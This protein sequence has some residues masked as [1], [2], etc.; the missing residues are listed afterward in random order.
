[1]TDK[2][3]Q[4]PPKPDQPT[5][6]EKPGELDLGE[7][8]LGRSALGQKSSTSPA[9]A[10]ILGLLIGV[11]AAAGAILGLGVGRP[12]PP[13]IA[14]ATASATPEPSA[15][16]SARAP[17]LGPLERAAQGDADA[18][19]ALEAR[20][21]DKR[22]AAE[23]IAL[24]RGRAAT[25][26][27]GIDEIKHKTEL[28]PDY[29]REKDTVS[30]IREYARD[31][32]MAIDVLEMLASLEGAVGPDLIFRIDRDRLV[33]D[34]DT[35]QLAEDL[36]YSSDV[37][38]KASPALS[39]VLDLDVAEACEEVAK[40]LERAKQHGDKRAEAA[41]GRFWM[42]RGCGENKALDC[43]P[44]LRNNDLLKDA[45]AEARKRPAQ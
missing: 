20:A 16:A 25:E 40:I 23:T 30:R 19:K 32:A 24:A 21:R 2:E 12:R 36:L 3:P 42:K 44:C 45:A 38:P 34:K 27:K 13:P 31:H 35:K 33:R 22:T 14:S 15:S 5:T 43:W 7:L 4:E 26:R 8:G 17:E 9:L 41:M 11:A 28:V 6:P 29:A 37:R 10:A 1:M 39:V 18:L